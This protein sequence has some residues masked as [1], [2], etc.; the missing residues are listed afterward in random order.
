[1]HAIRVADQ[2]KEFLKT[3]FIIFIEMNST[4]RKH[5]SYWAGLFHDYQSSQNNKIT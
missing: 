4:G 3:G 5:L 2:A 1:M